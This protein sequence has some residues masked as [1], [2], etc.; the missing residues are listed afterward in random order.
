MPVE[1]NKHGLKPSESIDVKLL[2]LADEFQEDI[3]KNLKQWCV[4]GKSIFYRTKNNWYQY[5]PNGAMTNCVR[6]NILTCKVDKGLAFTQRLHIGKSWLTKPSQ[7][8]KRLDTNFFK[9]IADVQKR[10]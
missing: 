2:I 7:V 6:Q 9:F 4:R 1:L 3:Y 8:E 10:G 5:R